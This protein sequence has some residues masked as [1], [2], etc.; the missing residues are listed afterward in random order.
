MP[1]NLLSPRRGLGPALALSLS[2]AAP[3]AAG[4]RVAADMRA[5][6]RQA[7][8]DARQ[9]IR[10]RPEEA[11]P[12]VERLRAVFE[13]LMGEYLTRSGDDRFQADLR[14]LYLA[15]CGREPAAPQPD[16]GD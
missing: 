7:F 5:L 12:E 15:A 3:V 11:C 6:L 4:D 8:A 16:D 10:Q 9:A 14:A 2:L 13:P 1:A